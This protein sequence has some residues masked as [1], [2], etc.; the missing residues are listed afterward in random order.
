MSFQAWVSL[1]RAQRK[2][3]MAQISTGG[4]IVLPG[5]YGTFEEALEMITWNQLG[6]HKL[7]VIILNSESESRIS[8]GTLAQSKRL[9]LSEWSDG[10]DAIVMR[11]MVAM[12]WLSQGWRL[13]STVNNLF[14]PLRK[15]FEDASESGFI[16]PENLSLV[17]IVDLPEGE[18]ANADESKAG[19]WGAAAVKALRDWSVSVSRQCPDP[20]LFYLDSSPLGPPFSLNIL[21]THSLHSPCP[22]SL[23]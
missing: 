13:I 7:P 9:F 1:N 10:D 17:S 21:R 5:G 8:R 18:A 6:I 14:T 22:H 12:Q 11:R 2:L 20:I 23:S 19:E 3:K 4:F 16:N 15:L